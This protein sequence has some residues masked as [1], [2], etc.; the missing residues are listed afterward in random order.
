M[1]LK[2]DF[3]I[4]PDP[5]GHRRDLLLKGDW[6]NVFLSSRQIIGRGEASHSGDDA[7]CLAK[8]QEL[9]ALHV[10]DRN[11]DLAL[12]RSLESGPFSTAPD[13]L[14]ATALSA[15][16][17]ALYDWVAQEQGLPVWNLFQSS[18][19]QASV[20]FYATIN[21]ALTT[22][23]PGDYRH[24]MGLA[25]ARGFT[26]I[27]CAPF[28]AVTPVGDQVAQAQA[29]LEMLHLLR[30]EFPQARLRV[31]FHQR[32]R[33]ENF[34]QILPQVDA[35]GLEWIE[36]PCPVGPVCQEI[37]RQA[38]TPIAAGELHFGPHRFQEIMTEGWADVIMPDVK[39]VGGFGPLVEVIR[40]AEKNGL[41]V[42]PHNPSG[43]TSTLASLQG[44]AVSTAVTS[45]EI[46]FLPDARSP[47][48][49]LIQG[50]RLIIPAGAGWGMA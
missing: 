7:R 27:K 24:V 14:T 48:E 33:V 1:S 34:L 42:S 11:V 36:E 5:A 44:A 43:P 28:E 6:L 39:H 16:N 18:P 10:A 49:K 29:G 45:L 37:R 25:Q 21:R 35:L 26:S 2:L 47:W 50:D 12:I 9:F 38:R 46:P 22:R 8:V 4:V 32:F 17:Q 13:F 31:D 15:L 40:R 41:A 23:T 19:A 20:E 3:E 30:R